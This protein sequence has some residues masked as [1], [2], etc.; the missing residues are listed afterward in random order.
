MASPLYEKPSPPSPSACF[1]KSTASA[2]VATS[3]MNPERSMSTAPSSSITRLWYLGATAGGTTG[4]R[5]GIEACVRG[6]RVTHA[7]PTADWEERAHRTKGRPTMTET[8][9]AERNSAQCC[10]V[11]EPPESRSESPPRKA[12]RQHMGTGAST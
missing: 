9:T 1:W 6:E 11:F 3:S 5:E 7:W 2:T 4:V 8:P 10:A 12:S